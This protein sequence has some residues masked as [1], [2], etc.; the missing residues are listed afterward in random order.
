MF[1]QG[2]IHEGKDLCHT[3]STICFPGMTKVLQN[4][5]LAGIVPLNEV[6]TL[7][8]EL[9]KYWLLDIAVFIYGMASE[10]HT[11]ERGIVPF[12]NKMVGFLPGQLFVH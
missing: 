5:C 3:R 2:I 11:N 10:C 1:R 9:L 7:V 4:F 6:N 8:K 12:I